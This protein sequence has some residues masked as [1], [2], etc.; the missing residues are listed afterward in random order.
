[1]ATQNFENHRRW[2][3]LYHFFVAPA[4][5]LFAIH[6]IAHALHQ[7]SVPHWMEVV[8]AVAVLGGMAAAR[9][10]A[11]R[12]QNRVVRLEMRLRMRDLLA[13]DL[14]AR[15]AT[16]RTKQLIALRFAGDAELPALVERTLAGEFASPNDIKRAITDWQPDY[17]RA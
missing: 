11:L 6:S 2:F 8:Y 3:P 13:P 16:L 9:I 14:Y 12:V 5:T 4:L 15:A 7:P 17:M 1:M 10:M